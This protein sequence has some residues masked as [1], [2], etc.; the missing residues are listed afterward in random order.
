[1]TVI[2]KN[3]FNMWSDGTTD[4]QLTLRFSREEE[5]LLITLK[6]IRLFSKETLSLKIAAAVETYVQQKIQAVATGS[7]VFTVVKDT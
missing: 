3:V 4:Q 1:M 5:A 7:G 2:L 6:I